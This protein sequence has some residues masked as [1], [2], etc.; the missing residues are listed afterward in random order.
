MLQ[1]TIDQEE[2]GVEQHV[3]IEIICECRSHEIVT[4]VN[5]S[6]SMIHVSPEGIH[7]HSCGIIVI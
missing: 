5:Q 2:T 4:G 1:R 6:I 7:G 3:F